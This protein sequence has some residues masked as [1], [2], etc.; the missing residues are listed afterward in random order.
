LGALIGATT[1]VGLALAVTRHITFPWADSIL[2]AGYVMGIVATAH[3]AIWAATGE[4][5]P[6]GRAAA[7]LV[8]APVT[9][10]A[11]AAIEPQGPNDIV[12]FATAMIVEAGW[13]Y[14]GILV[15]RVAGYRLVRMARE[16]G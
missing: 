11:L 9:G 1:V 5:A 13:I 10:M 3:L 7:V 16:A 14:V 4:T 15:Q 6:W 2:V 12:T 8:A